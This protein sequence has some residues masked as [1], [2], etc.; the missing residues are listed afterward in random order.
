MSR[1]RRRVDGD[2]TSNY[3]V[4]VMKEFD[5]DVRVGDAAVEFTV[6]GDGFVFQDLERLLRHLVV[7]QQN[8]RL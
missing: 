8:R 5:L 1:K 3:L 2:Q 6:E 7:D 4:V